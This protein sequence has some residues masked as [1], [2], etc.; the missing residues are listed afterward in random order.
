MPTEQYERL[1]GERK[2]ER[3]QLRVAAYCRVSTDSRDQANSFASQQTFFRSYIEKHREWTLCG[4]FADSGASG[5]STS[6]RPEFLRLMEH[7]QQ[8][9][10]DLIITKEISRFARN[11]L[12]SIYY[13]RTLR[14]LGVGVIF[15]SDG[16]NTL[17]GDAELRLAILSSLAQEESRRT[18]ERG[19]WG[20]RR[21]ME[22]GVVF[23]RSML[24]YD[25]RGGVM[26]VNPEG[27]EVVRRIFSKFLDEGKGVWRIAREL[28]EEGVRPMRAEKWNRSVVLR[29][30][31]NE[32]YCGDLVQQKT[33]TP[34][35]LTHE[36]KA[37]HGQ[38]EFVILRGHHEPIISRERFERANTL[39]DER[40]R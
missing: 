35:F 27:A 14:R 11:T 18:S 20:Q 28:D 38:E 22:Q 34:D 13:T 32:K 1:N 3:T 7:A 31:R 21:R 19:K 36:K 40:R 23:G 33:C 25:V 39:L 8:G 12:D 15:L 5:T 9:A 6:K 16:I 4:I 17:E 2:T 30:L 29:I 26:T 37:N 10:V 24:G